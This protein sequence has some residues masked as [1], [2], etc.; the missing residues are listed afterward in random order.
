MVKKQVVKTED[1]TEQMDNIEEPIDTLIDGSDK[2]TVKKAVDPQVSVLNRY[3]VEKY[4][5]DD[6]II[7]ERVILNEEYAGTK[8]VKEFVLPN[9]K[10]VYYAERQVKKYSDNVVEA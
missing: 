1:N 2:T 7:F 8:G 10:I 3:R 9:G 6:A 5:V 4:G